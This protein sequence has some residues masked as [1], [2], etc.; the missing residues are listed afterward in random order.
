[1]G[2]IMRRT[3]VCCSNKPVTWCNE[4]MCNSHGPKHTNLC[5]G[6]SKRC[7]LQPNKGKGWSWWFKY[8]YV[9]FELLIFS[10]KTLSI[11]VAL[12]IGTW[13]FLWTCCFVYGSWIY[14]M[15]L[16]QCSLFT[17]FIKIWWRMG[18]WW[19]CQQWAGNKCLTVQHSWNWNWE[20]PFFLFLLME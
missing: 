8:L 1:M 6:E 17:P 20:V 2:H 11:I 13:I 12:E 5:T 18:F 19:S 3:M 16:A 4:W 7:T 15:I 14:S 9:S 10:L